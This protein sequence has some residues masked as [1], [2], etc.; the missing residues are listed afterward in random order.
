VSDFAVDLRPGF[1]LE[2]GLSVALADNKARRPRPP[3]YLEYSYC[4][5]YGFA[6]LAGANFELLC[7]P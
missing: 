3:R 5:I 7:V 4:F 6:L 1:I 2:I